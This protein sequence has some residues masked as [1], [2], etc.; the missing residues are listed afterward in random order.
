MAGN[1]YA[2]ASRKKILEFLKGNSDRTVTAADIDDYLRGSGSEVNIT[3]IYRYL[4]KLC[5]RREPSLNM[6]QR[7]VEKR[8]ISMWSLD[9]GARNT[10]I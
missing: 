10:C 6:W 3:T 4:D 7:R 9:I 1:G 2:T 8:H 5:Q